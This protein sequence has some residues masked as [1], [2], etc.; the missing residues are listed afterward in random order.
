M[1]ELMTNIPEGTSIE[2]LI[3]HQ[4]VSGRRF[5]GPEE[6]GLTG[7]Q[8][9]ASCISLDGL[10]G[11]GTPGGECAQCPKNMFGKES[12]SISSKPCREEAVLF[13]IPGTLG[14]RLFYSILIPWQ[15]PTVLAVTLNDPRECANYRRYTMA[16]TGNRLH[17][18]QI[19]TKMVRLWN[20]ETKRA[21]TKYVMRGAFP[22]IATGALRRKRTELIPEMEDFL[23]DYISR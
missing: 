3:I 20:R 18:Y 4:N 19:C 17:H 1:I 10:T 5:A 16:I 21:E 23:K 6:K 9:P 8:A 22:S 14:P 7:R 11:T 2:G 15:T 13:V 12:G